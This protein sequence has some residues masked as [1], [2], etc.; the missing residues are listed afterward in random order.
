MG[1]LI[2]KRGDYM[3]MNYKDYMDTKVMIEEIRKLSKNN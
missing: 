1:F 3:E 2:L